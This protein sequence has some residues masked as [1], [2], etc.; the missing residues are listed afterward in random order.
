MKDSGR[1]TRRTGRAHMCI[2]QGRN[3]VVVGWE[4]KEKGKALSIIIQGM[5]IGG[6][7]N[8]G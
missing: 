4:M 5:S 1:M 8:K 2:V 6:D 7:G 3:T